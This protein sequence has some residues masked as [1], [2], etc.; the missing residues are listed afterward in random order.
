MCVS[1]L[2]RNVSGSPG[3]ARA[4]PV[5]DRD[6]SLPAARGLPDHPPKSGSLRASD[7]PAQGPM[8]YL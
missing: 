2:K 3:E 4:D 5:H 6:G 8:Y 7:H 1:I